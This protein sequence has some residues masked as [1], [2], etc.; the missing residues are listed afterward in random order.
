MDINLD[1]EMKVLEMCSAISTLRT[2]ALID[3][4]KLESIEELMINEY[5]MK[6]ELEE[7]GVSKDN[8]L[9]GC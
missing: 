6:K 2:K 1:K 8:L 3:N 5:E 7:I 4:M 9:F